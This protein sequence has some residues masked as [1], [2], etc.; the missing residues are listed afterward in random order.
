MQLERVI[1]IARSNFPVRGAQKPR[2]NVH[3]KEDQSKHH[4]RFQCEKEEREKRKAPYNQV[5][6]NSRIVADTY[7]TLSSISCARVGRRNL[8]FWQVEHAE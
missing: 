2:A 7:S 8:P 1:E 3:Q 6:S 5:E 4:V